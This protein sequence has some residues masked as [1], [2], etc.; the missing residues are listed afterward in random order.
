MK[1]MPDAKVIVFNA[2]ALLITVAAVA[3]LARSLIT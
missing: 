2:A 1:K 3:G